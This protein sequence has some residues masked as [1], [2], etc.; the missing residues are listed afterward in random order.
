MTSPKTDETI[1]EKYRG[2]K[3]L[4]FGDKFRIEK[5]VL[6]LF[7]MEGAWKPHKGYFENKD[8]SVWFPKRDHE[9]YCDYVSDDY[10]YI[11]EQFNHSEELAKHN[12]QNRAVFIRENDMLFFRGVYRPDSLF[13]I[14]GNTYTLWRRTNHTVRSLLPDE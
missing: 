10:S 5:D 6:I 11:L 14:N 3:P 8:V 9:K 1:L 12:Y 13:Q 4:R 2:Y 7:N